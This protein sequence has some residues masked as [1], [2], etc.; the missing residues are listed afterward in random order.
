[1]SDEASGRTGRR[2]GSVSTRDA[3]LRAARAEFSRR[4]YKGATLRA[5]ASAAEVDPALIRHFFGGKE[6]LFTAAMEMPIDALGT[7]LEAFEGP[8]EQWGERLARAYLSLWDEPPT[9]APIRTAVVSAFG[10][11]Q[12]MAQLRDFIMST[13]MESLRPRLPDDDP[14]LRLTTAVT[15]IVGIAIGRYILRVPPLAEASLED[16]VALIAPSVQHYL[17]GSLHRG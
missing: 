3:I 5:I 9:A 4:G 15:H 14:E 13:I 11:E 17:T 1:M 7:I 12:A 2:P 16:L 6:G 10:N 8:R